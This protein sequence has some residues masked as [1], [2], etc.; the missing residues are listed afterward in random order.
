MPERTR[1]PLIGLL[2]S[3]TIS[4]FGTRMSAL[5]LPWFVLVTTG[6]V[7]RTGLVAFAEMTPYVLVGAVGGPFVDRVGPVRA[8]V[9]GNLAAAVAVGTVPVLHA[10]DLLAFGTLLAVVAVAGAAAGLAGA[11]LRVLV[12]ATGTLAGTPLER[13]AG[14]FDG[15][16]RLAT[17]LG[18]SVAGALLVVASA[19]VVLAIDAVTFAVCALIL[20]GTVP[21]SVQPRQ[22][23]SASYLTDLRAGFGW[24]GRQR[25]LLGICLLVFV[26]NLVDQ[27]WSAVLLP[28]WVRDE[29]GDPG[30][31]GA[32]VTAFGIGAVAG[33]ALFTWLGP[34]LPRRRTFAWAFLIAGPPHLL[35]LAVTPGLPAVLVV[36]ALSGLTGG[37]LNPIIG[38][39]SYERVPTE[40]RARVL[41][42]INS[43]TWAG[44]P[45][46]G[47]LGGWLA[48]IAGLTA[49][50]LVGGGIYLLATLG[51][52]VFP[53]WR[54]MDRRPAAPT[55]PQAAGSEP[56][57]ADEVT[58]Q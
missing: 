46:G 25:L 29:I 45:L 55:E 47:L 15:L 1:R 50:L 53:A 54:D 56:D 30:A 20:L 10:A 24:L 42:A 49:A 7:T 57:G 44:I 14:L 3:A 31:L 34:R 40:L 27:A 38:A 19:P 26:T 2:T 52:F 39:V 28:A 37:A 35:V 23:A 16:S 58:R 22:T 8:A 21:A 41:P 11:G 9:A 43:L 48:G 32:I 4:I 51:P 36:T 17:L 12:P 6:S 33:N 18:A 5:A 13:V